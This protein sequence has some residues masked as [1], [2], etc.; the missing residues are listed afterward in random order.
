MQNMDQQLAWVIQKTNKK[1]IQAKIW[2][3][4]CYNVGLSRNIFLLIFVSNFRNVC[5][6]LKGTVVTCCSSEILCDM[7]SI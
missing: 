3:C 2:E 5:L 1:K 7:Y 6:V 4:N